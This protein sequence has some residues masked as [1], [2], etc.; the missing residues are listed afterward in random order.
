MNGFIHIFA[1]QRGLWKRENR[2]M[3]GNFQPSIQLTVIYFRGAFCEHLVWTEE[4]WLFV[5]SL[6]FNL[7]FYLVCTWK[8]WRRGFFELFWRGII[9]KSKIAKVWRNGIYLHFFVSRTFAF[10]LVSIF[11]H[12]LR[13][14]IF[15]KVEE[16]LTIQIRT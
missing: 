7:N 10:R 9:N 8:K 14:C 16:L 3:G 5:C 13:I 12:W 4:G 15:K 11:I 1:I 6:L 2:K